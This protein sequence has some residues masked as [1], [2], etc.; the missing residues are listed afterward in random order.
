MRRNFLTRVKQPRWSVPQAGWVLS[1][2]I[3]VVASHSPS[4]AQ[5]QGLQGYWRGSGYIAPSKGQR[6]RVR[7][8]VWISS[9]SAK[10]YRV[11]A[12]CASQAA[13]IDQTGRVR[14]TGRNSYIGDFFNSDFNIR[15]RL[16]I[17]LRG[18]R[19]SVTMHSNSGSGR[20]TLF[21]R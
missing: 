1:L 3:L 21:R 5:S 8:R 17:T 2:L 19:Q 20:L 6:E 11:K 16:R 12:Q 10:T 13:N 9:S 14:K 15:G 18:N 7:C 4:E